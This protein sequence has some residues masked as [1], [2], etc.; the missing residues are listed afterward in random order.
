MRT[1]CLALA[2]LGVTPFADARPFTAD[3]LVTLER[4][5]DPQAS[6]DGRHVVFVLRETDMDANRGRT[7]LWQLDLPDGQP[8]RLTSAS[9]NDSQPRWSADG[10]AIYFLSTRSGSSQV[11]R[12]PADGGEAQPVT[13]LPLDVGAF[14]LS[15][16]GDRLVVAI[17]VFLDCADLACTKARLDERAKD[18]RSGRLY[19][20]LFVRH[21][22]TWSDGRR[23]ALHSLAL[24]TDGKAVG[25]AVALTRTLDADI[26][27]KPFGGPEDFS[28]SPDGRE[29]FFSARIA[30]TTEPWS[31]N[32]DVFRVPSDGSGAPENL[33][34]ANKA[35]DAQPI[36]SPDGR[37]L[38]YLAM[39]RPGYE[40]DR[41]RLKLRDLASGT[42]RVVAEDWD[43][44]VASFTFA[45]SGRALLATADSV[46]QHPLFRIDL[47]SGRVSEIVGQGYVSGFT[48][49]GDRVVLARDDLSTPAD[50]YSVSASG[51]GLKRLTQVNAERLADVEMGAFEQFTFA[52]WNGETVHG[53]VVSPPNR[54]ANRKA[55]VAFLIHGGPQ[56]S[57]ANQFH[58][59]WNPQV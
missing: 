24:G 50:L 27:S 29:V 57:F 42:E 53:F 38:A 7:S 45:P 25:E 48:F 6:P 26:P 37:S 35:W 58:Y 14:A 13:E 2:L 12:L 5:S 11:W 55:P 44:S 19:D 52:G 47:P 31:T 49:A 17:E 51:S 9:G 10:R 41:F 15:P 22:D 3:D 28:L 33:T 18:K 34:E 21:W 56:G 32:F 54:N 46:G 8:R 1:L 30:G 40:S 59:R 39:T 23:S 4:I 43:R 36:V 16:R 20:H